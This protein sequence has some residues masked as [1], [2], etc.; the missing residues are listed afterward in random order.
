MLDDIVIF[1]AGSQ[2]RA[3]GLVGSVLLVPWLF[4]LTAMSG[5][6]VMLLGLFLP[7]SD[8]VFWYLTR[9]NEWQQKVAGK[10]RT[11][12]LRARKEGTYGPGK[13]NRKST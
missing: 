5:Q 4:G 7:A 2:V 3:A 1:Y 11:R 12:N 13:R 6:G 8:P 10:L 9:F